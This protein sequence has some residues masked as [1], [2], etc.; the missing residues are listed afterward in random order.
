MHD[1]QY[2]DVL[3][4]NGTHESVLLGNKVTIVRAE[5]LL[6]LNQWLKF[7]E[8][9]DLIRHGLMFLNEAFGAMQ[10]I[11]SDDAECLLKILWRCVLLYL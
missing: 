8:R 9:F 2:E 3:V 6:F 10:A 4:S 5:V 11:L 7:W 1:S